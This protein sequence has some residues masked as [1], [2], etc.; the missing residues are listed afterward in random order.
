[1]YVF[2]DHKG[3]LLYIGQSKIL[4]KRFGAH[5]SQGGL[6]KINA[7]AVAFL[8]VPRECWFEIL[9]IE[10][11]LIERLQPPFNKAGIKKKSIA[12]GIILPTRPQKIQ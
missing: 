4:G 1:M 6:T 7:G 3:Q 2:F 12:E 10:A 11:Y 8:P 5:F 9:A